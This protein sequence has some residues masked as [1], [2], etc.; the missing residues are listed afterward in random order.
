MESRF[1]CTACDVVTTC[2][3]TSG[4]CPHVVVERA[5]KNGGENT[6]TMLGYNRQRTQTCSG[7]LECKSQSGKDNRVAHWRIET[8]QRQ[9]SCEYTEPRGKGPQEKRR[10]VPAVSG[11]IHEKKFQHLACAAVSPLARH[12]NG[13]ASLASLAASTGL[14]CLPLSPARFSSIC[15]ATTSCRSNSNP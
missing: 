8:R 10:L 1:P 12:F 7:P 9:C 6:V 5:S 14:E 13:G 11:N 3:R 15:S 2:C 4:A